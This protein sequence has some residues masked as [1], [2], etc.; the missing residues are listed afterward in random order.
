M[1]ANLSENRRQIVH[2]LVGGGSLLLRLL[3]WWQAALCAAAAAAFNAWILPRVQ[4]RLFR[5]GDFAAPWRSGIVIYPLAVLALILV[6]RDEPAVAAAAWAILA[7]GDGAATLVGVTVKTPALSWNRQKTIGGLA[8]FVLIGGAAGVAAAAWTIGAVPTASSWTLVAPLAAAV[9][10]G[11]AESAP[12]GLDDN[13]TVPVTAAVALWSLG[14]VDADALAAAHSVI[15]SRWWTA[16][17]LN[18]AVAAIGWRAGTVTPAGAA[19]GA[20]IGSAVFIGAGW[21]GWTLLFVSFLAAAIATRAGYRRKAGAGIAE[22]RGGRR[23]PG[24]AIANTGVAAWTALLSLGL[25]APQSPLA[26]LAMVAALVTASSD[27]VASEIGK[28]WG[29]RTWLVTTL[30]AVPRGTPGAVSV[31]GTAAGI[32]AAAALAWFA[33]ALGLIAGRWVPPVVA[34]ATVAALAEGALGA[35]LERRGLLNN[36]ALNLINAVLGATLAV[37]LAGAA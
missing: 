37:A 3:T 26:M 12:L 30:G 6:F 29:R 14:L 33:S 34:A 10:A 2:M 32:A 20:A 24:N 31:E 1:T 16:L 11:L 5:P 4:P 36:D 35:T 7:F 28:A 19:T 27:T 18:A 8:A 17:G 13:I 15:T 23:G 9:L 22:D 25:P 21:P